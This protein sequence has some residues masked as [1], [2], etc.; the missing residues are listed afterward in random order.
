[1]KSF[2]KFRKF[3]SL[4]SE[5]LQVLS[6]KP[7]LHSSVRHL[8]D[9]GCK[10]TFSETGKTGIAVKAGV[11]NLTLSIAGVQNLLPLA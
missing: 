2:P 4:F 5:M 11:P 9:S 8:F 3:L 1:M 6:S 10:I 7:R